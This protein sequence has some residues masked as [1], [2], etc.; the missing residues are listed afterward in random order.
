MEPKSHKKQQKTTPKNTSKKTSE[1]TPKK[2]PKSAPRVS[3][4]RRF[5]TKKA[6]G[7]KQADLHETLVILE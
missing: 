3:C 6:I 1:K 5:G 7:T 4:G 2:L